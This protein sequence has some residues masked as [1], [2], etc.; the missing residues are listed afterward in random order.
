MMMKMLCTGSLAFDH[1]CDDGSDGLTLGDL[2]GT[3]SVYD[4]GYGGYDGY[5]D[6]HNCANDEMT[7]CSQNCCGCHAC[8]GWSAITGGDWWLSKELSDPKSH[9]HLEMPWLQPALPQMDAFCGECD[10]QCGAC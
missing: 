1:P 9:Y 5:F 3:T 4:D 6:E 7:F 10:E 8:K 2:E